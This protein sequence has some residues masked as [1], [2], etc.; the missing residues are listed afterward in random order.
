ML[1]EE[2]RDRAAGLSGVLRT[3]GAVHV[4]GALALGDGLQRL[5]VTYD[6]RM[7]EVASAAVLPAYGP[8]MT[9]RARR[10]PAARRL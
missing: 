2:V 7:P 10:A 6:K 1:T 4:A 9:D 3:L 8:G 5:D